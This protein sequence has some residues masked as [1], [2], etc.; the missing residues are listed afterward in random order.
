MANVFFRAQKRS[1]RRRGR[2]GGN[3]KRS[4]SRPSQGR[5]PKKISLGGYRNVPREELLE[6]LH[7]YKDWLLTQQ[8][9]EDVWAAIGMAVATEGQRQARTGIKDKDFRNN[10]R[11]YL[12]MKAWN[13]LMHALN[14]N[15]AFGGYVL[16]WV[17]RVFGF[18]GEDYRTTVE[19]TDNESYSVSIKKVRKHEPVDISFDTPT[20]EYTP[21]V[22][23]SSLLSSGFCSHCEFCPRQSGIRLSRSVDYSST[24]V[25]LGGVTRTAVASWWIAMPYICVHYSARDAEWVASLFKATNGFPIADAIVR[26]MNVPT[27]KIGPSGCGHEPLVEGDPFDPLGPISTG[28]MYRPQETNDGHRCPV[29]NPHEPHY[30]SKALG[31]AIFGTPS[32]VFRSQII[33]A[34]FLLGH[35]RAAQI[36]R[37]LRVAEVGIVSLSDGYGFSPT[38]SS[39]VRTVIVL[40]S[41]F[42]VALPEGPWDFVVVQLNSFGGSRSVALSRIIVASMVPPSVTVYTLNARTEGVFVPSYVDFP[43][44]PIVSCYRSNLVTPSAGVARIPGGSL[45][46][47]STVDLLRLVRHAAYYGVDELIM[48][49]SPFVL[50]AASSPCDPEDAVRTPQWSWACTAYYQVRRVPLFV[51]VSRT[52]RQVAAQALRRLSAAVIDIPPSAGAGSLHVAD[53]RDW[54]AP[55]RWL[56]E[57]PVSRS[58]T[59]VISFVTFGTRGDHVPLRPVMCYLASLGFNVFHI[60]ATTQD[61]GVRML[62]EAETEG[63][64]SYSAALW[65]D[66]IVGTQAVRGTVFA[67]SM[68]NSGHVSFTYEGPSWWVAPSRF[69]LPFGL[70]VLKRLFFDPTDLMRVAPFPDV[71]CVPRS[72]GLDDFETFVPN[73]GGRQRAVFVQGSTSN[74]MAPDGVPVLP[75]PSDHPTELAKYDIAY[76][77]GL[78]TAYTAAAAG[79]R[80]FMMSDLLDRNVKNNTNAG[81]GMKF[82]T[83]PERILSHYAL[84]DYHHARRV[85]PLMSFWGK[86]HLLRLTLNRHGIRLLFGLMTLFVVLIRIPR[87]IHL[88][89]GFAASTFMLLF[90]EPTPT[91]LLAVMVVVRVVTVYGSYYPAVIIRSFFSIT[92][93]LISGLDSV[94]VYL[95][96]YSGYSFVASCLLAWITFLTGRFAYHV[97]LASYA[98]VINPKSYLQARYFW[99]GILPV[100]HTRFINL[101][102]TLIAEGEFTGPQGAFVPY[103]WK[104]KDHDD[105]NDPDHWMLTIPLTVEWNE[106]AGSRVPGGYYSIF[107][108]C[109]TMTLNAVSVA[110][111]RLGLAIFVLL[112]LT[113]FTSVAM[114]CYFVLTVVCVFFMAL[115][116]PVY[117][118]ARVNKRRQ[119][120]MVFE[121]AWFSLGA[122]LTPADGLFDWTMRMSLIAQWQWSTSSSALGKMLLE[123]PNELSADDAVAHLSSIYM[124]E[125]GSSMPISLRELFRR[126]L[127]LARP[128][129]QEDAVVRLP[130]LD[131]ILTGEHASREIYEALYLHLENGD[132]DAFIEHLA[133]LLRAFT[134]GEEETNILVTIYEG[135]TRFW[136]A[137]IE[138]DEAIRQLS[139]VSG[140]IPAHLNRFIRY[141]FFKDAPDVED[142]DGAIDEETIE[143]AGEIVATLVQNGSD[144]EETLK[145][146]AMEYA[147]YE[148]IASG[149]SEGP[150]YALAM[151]NEYMAVVDKMRVHYDNLSAWAYHVREIAVEHGVFI[152]AP[153]EF[154]TLLTGRV[155]ADMSRL[156]AIVVQPLL[157][158]WEV[159]VPGTPLRNALVVA[160]ASFLDIIDVRHRVTPKPA[161]ALLLGH[162]KFRLSRG[163][164]MLASFVSTRY[165]RPD[166]YQ[167]WASKMIEAMRSKEVNVDVLLQDPPTRALFF[168]RKTYG[169]KSNEQFIEDFDVTIHETERELRRLRATIKH[170]G[171]PAIDQAW[172]ATAENMAVSL[173]RYTVER[174]VVNLRGHAKIIEASD[175]LFDQFSEMYDQPRGMSVGGVIAASV[176]KYSPGLPFIPVFK[177]RAEIKNSAWIH[178]FRQAAERLLAS[179]EFPGIALHAFPKNQLVSLDSLQAGKPIRTV[180]AGDRLTA[181]MYNT[182]AMERNKRPPPSRALI[183]PGFTRTEGG[184]LEVY[185]RLAAQPHFFTGD[186]HRFDS[187]VVSELAIEAPVRLWQRGVQGNWGERT[188]TT[189]MRAYY[190]G[191]ADGIIVNLKDGTVVRKTGGGATGSAA[192]SPDNR[193]WV[194]VA[195]IATWSIVTGL[196]CVDFFDH[197]VLA[198]ASDDIAFSCD[199]LTLSKV[200]EWR[201]ALKAEYGVAFDFEPGVDVSG[202]LHL[203]VVDNPDFD[204]Y[205][206]VGVTPPETSIAHDPARLFTMRSEYRADRMNHQWLRDYD[207]VATQAVG[208]SLL[209]A[210]HPSAYS[211]IAIDYEEAALGMMCHFFKQ[212]EV[213]K[214]FDDYGN[215]VSCQ[216]HVTCAEP[217]APLLKLASRYPPSQ[218]D[219]WIYSSQKRARTWLKAKR[220]PSYLEVFKMWVSAPPPDRAVSRRYRKLPFN[221]ASPFVDTLRNG[222]DYVTSVI[223]MYPAALK[224]LEG[225]PDLVYIP[226]RFVST[227]H[228][229]E[230]YIFYRAC[231]RLGRPPTFSEMSSLIRQSPFQGATDLYGFMLRVRDGLESDK[232]LQ[233]TPKDKSTVALRV[234]CSMIVYTVSDAILRWLTQFRILG[235]FLYVVFAFLLGADTV[236]AALSLAHWIGTGMASQAVSNIVLKDPYLVLKILS[237]TIVNAVPF[238]WVP[239][240]LYELLTHVRW[241]S[242]VFLV[243]AQ[244]RMFIPQS[245]QGHLSPPRDTPMAPICGQLLTVQRQFTSLLV[246][247]MGSGKSTLLPSYLLQEGVDRVILLMPTN[248]LVNSYTNEFVAQDLIH[249]H[250]KGTR[251]NLPVRG[252]CVM[253]YGMYLTLFP[254]GVMPSQERPSDNLGD[255]RNTAVLLDEVGLGSGDQAV[256]LV[257]SRACLFRMVVGLTGTP[258][259]SLCSAF[260]RRFSITV[261]RRFLME[262]RLHDEEWP[263]L[264]GRALGSTG[265]TGRMLAI[266]PARNQAD[267]LCASLMASHGLRATVVSRENPQAPLDGH[268]IATSIADTG[269]NILPPPGSLADSGLVV[270]K[271]PSIVAVND[272]LGN[273]FPASSSSAARDSLYHSCFM[274]SSQSIA[275][276]RANRV[277][278]AANGLVF[279]PPKAGTGPE[280]AG[281]VSITMLMSLRREVHRQVISALSM[282]WPL[283]STGD[284]VSG[285]LS[286]DIARARAI[287]PSFVT[288]QVEAFALW[289]L[290]VD[291]GGI[292]NA[293]QELLFN[294][295]SSEQLIACYNAQ[296]LEAP[297]PQVFTDALYD[298]RLLQAVSVQLI[299]AP[300]RAR[301][302]M[303]FDPIGNQWLMV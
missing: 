135:F 283:S 95:F 89:P 30:T 66:V 183:L 198:N 220:L 63:I 137:D 234:V 215:V 62:A 16:A 293:R 3:S 237:V 10:L 245:V 191:L 186:A 14:G 264:C 35:H 4:G 152:Y 180:T 299:D 145:A 154:M 7:N 240:G 83:S 168:P 175:A 54:D 52:S 221:V 203:R 110:R 295:G 73:T 189:F 36:I 8:G 206:S 159:T 149:G 37:N 115:T 67:P 256:A 45:R 270:M 147:G 276:Q 199:D 210:H 84:V 296:G 61:E 247:N 266:Y 116:A 109:Q 179:G 242:D 212:V 20:L 259:S 151:F 249:L 163:D 166:S 26:P 291:V 269:V 133:D 86:L 294:R 13:K 164:A 120:N 107:H 139:D 229:Y 284:G 112:P 92:S 301:R 143:A 173:S 132:G 222:T 230:R 187:T 18:T 162:H 228:T 50:I 68:L 82:G 196:P 127:G 94:L 227:D 106:I 146:V 171:S 23:M 263:L 140:P 257:L 113:L 195:L 124:R 157:A 2:K 141:F 76:V 88:G 60:P 273:A 302:L 80:V 209:T 1:N 79:C 78:G 278:R 72:S 202:I 274:W 165:V 15:I 281:G 47:A 96:Y 194:R 224:K 290:T 161:W 25:T 69:A 93:A 105:A 250:K 232:L 289:M 205:V 58:E 155:V 32:D 125:T 193:D 91:L 9:G 99:I 81:L 298:F 286:F 87:R 174:P 190:Q 216:I 90:S 17:R 144:F 272:D 258:S 57:N 102:H 285:W 241:I 22:M 253:T 49:T 223:R 114:F 119:V 226:G 169:I 238:P 153:L 178:A 121:K 246:A 188:T 122:A 5:V 6:R 279:R 33:M 261:R 267:R 287:D 51:K 181:T 142:V 70:D 170:G 29:C 103:Y 265:T 39:P 292:S 150:D 219:Q 192:T 282:G 262:V 300:L 277:G 172:L 236:Y 201:E 24:L 244:T 40:A 71:E 207:I 28:M 288:R 128:A 130:N 34:T 27:A 185:Q 134:Y 136:Y 104:V 97:S 176:W 225:E 184:M 118:I 64:S 239:E 255:V 167:E 38:W 98:A 248:L 31:D 254:H 65:S 218:R 85:W 41:T 214:L 77:T 56:A 204:S 251:E 129:P 303:A 275:D 252:I 108:N 48:L 243:G 217:A 260:D 43:D 182:L 138:E 148:H 123:L 111:V 42:D 55:G 59:H 21:D 156:A 297:E 131:D 12:S 74:V 53:L 213:E 211:D 235:T 75:V 208:H 271:F 126:L 11:G 117:A 160:F 101:D 200:V 46:C 197:V 177:S 19:L 100:V 280:L 268:V 44:V 158:R 233:P 231:D